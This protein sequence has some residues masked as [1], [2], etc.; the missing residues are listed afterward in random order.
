[1]T[2]GRSERLL[3]R[4]SLL[5]RDRSVDGVVYH[6]LGS[7]AIDLPY[8]S[9]PAVYGG[10]RLEGLVAARQSREIL[11]RVRDVAPGRLLIFKGPEIA[12]RYPEPYH[13]AYSDL[14]VLAERPADVHRALR[15]AGWDAAHAGGH[16]DCTHQFPPLVDAGTAL[17]IEVHRRLAWPAWVRAPRPE[18]LL[19]RAVPSRLDIDGLETLDPVD[20]TLQLCAHSW[21]HRPFR[22]LR[23]L[24]DVEL[25][26][27]E[28]DA[29]E[30]DRRAREWGLEKLWR[31]TVRASDYLF[32]GIGRCPFG[33]ALLGRHVLAVRRTS[34]GSEIAMKALGR[35]AVTT[36][37][38]A[39]QSAW[40]ELAIKVKRDEL[41]SRHSRGALA[42]V[43]TAE[44]GA[45]RS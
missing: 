33:L 10:A 13:R 9:S 15:E 20:H 5:L 31:L 29:R 4:V 17:P 22:T 14:D 21:L 12:A 38:R 35:F 3:E 43:R 24:L 28:C 2:D 42:A 26:R 8:E 7:L 44:R 23:D 32:H 27:R 25:L 37:W 6:G 36:P 30:L 34:R 1:M 16:F 45:V 11:Q 39:L 18:A 40:V 19:E 41:L